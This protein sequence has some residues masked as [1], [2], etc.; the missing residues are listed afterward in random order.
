[1]RVSTLIMI[2]L[3]GPQ[4]SGEVDRAAAASWVGRRVES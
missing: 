1:L 4:T 2:T 3:P